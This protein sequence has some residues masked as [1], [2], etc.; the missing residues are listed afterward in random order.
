MT[1]EELAAI[2]ARA[3]AAPEPPWT[4]RPVT[5]P[6]GDIRC[7]CSDAYPSGWILYASEEADLCVHDDTLQFVLHAREDVPKLIAE[8]RRLQA[9]NRSLL[10]LLA[11]GDMAIPVDELGGM[12][13][14]NFC[15]ER[16]GDL[17]A[18]AWICA[19]CRANVES[20]DDD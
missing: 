2:E 1:E 16:E 20:D 9:E 3:N 6:G 19:K 8:V 11:R 15:D 12:P 7:I 10:T 18:T 4:T 14:C 13:E 5:G 17:M